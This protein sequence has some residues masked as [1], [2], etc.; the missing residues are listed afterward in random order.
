M[1][2]L[3]N[4]PL[5]E[6]T[7]L[8]LPVR[9]LTVPGTLRPFLWYS[10]KKLDWAKSFYKACCWHTWWVNFK[11]FFVDTK[12]SNHN[13]KGWVCVQAKT[14]A[15]QHILFARRKTGRFGILGI[16]CLKFSRHPQWT[17]W[18]IFLFLFWMIENQGCW[19]C[20]KNEN[21]SNLGSWNERTVLEQ[22]GKK[23]KKVEKS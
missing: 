6:R 17:Q 13:S 15:L 9:L 18:T 4:R 11:G 10:L 19:K 7:E 2:L 1:A 20:W 23:W 3:K 8:I 21:Q 14:S 22:S 5:F 12:N 16:S